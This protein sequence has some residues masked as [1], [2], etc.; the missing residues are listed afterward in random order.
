MAFVEE[1]NG[2]D[3][4]KQ[5]ELLAEIDLRRHLDP[6]WPTDGG[7]AHGPEQNGIG[8]ADAVERGRRERVAAAEKFA[9]ADGVF[10]ELEAS[11]GEQSFDGAE[12]LD[13]FGDDF[14][15]DSIAAEDCDLKQG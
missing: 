15:A 14:G 9:G 2:P 5:I 7:Q 10:N 8:L 12:D 4:V 11:A 1:T 6:A 13:A 3:A